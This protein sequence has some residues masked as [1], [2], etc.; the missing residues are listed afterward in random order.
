MGMNV[1][2]GGIEDDVMMDINT[3]PLIDV[4]LL[5]IIMV[6]NTIQMQTTAVKMSMPVGARWAP[7]KQS[8]IVRINDGFELTLAS[9]GTVLSQ[10]KLFNKLA[11]TASF[12]RPP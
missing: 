8:D 9:N 7:S 11:Q 4:M 2:S 6:I 10:Y 5:L 12:P 1:G 3:T